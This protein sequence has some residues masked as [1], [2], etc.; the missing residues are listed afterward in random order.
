MRDHG[1]VAAVDMVVEV[2]ASTA[3][4]AEAFMAAVVALTSAVAAHTSVAEVLTS[5]EPISVAEV[6]TLAARAVVAR[7]SAADILPAGEL[8]AFAAVATRRTSP[9][10]LAISVATRSARLTPEPI[11]RARPAAAVSATVTLRSITTS[12]AT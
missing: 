12:A 5:A 1:V 8:A 11:S 3:V 10:A 9:E 6:R 7:I 2:A 4:E